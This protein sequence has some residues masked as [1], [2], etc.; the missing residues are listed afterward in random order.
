MSFRRKVITVNDKIA[1]PAM[2]VTRVV[3]VCYG[4]M[5]ATIVI[6]TGIGFWLSYAGLHSFAYRAGLRGPECWAWP[7][8]VDLFI[9]C[10]ELGIALSTLRDGKHDWRAWTYFAL[11]AVPSVTF[12]VMHVSVHSLAWA[13]YA[14]AATPPVTAALALAA[15][16]AQVIALPSVLQHL[17]LAEDTAVSDVAESAAAESP[18]S[19]PATQAPGPDSGPEDA[20]A[21]TT[22]QRPTKADP[23]PRKAVAR[24][25]GKRV[26]RTVAERAHAKYGEL[27]LSGA[28]VPSIRRIKSDLRLG[29]PKATEARVHLA[30]LSTSNG[31]AAEGD[32][33]D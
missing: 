30:T 14:V 26:S 8:S 10:G 4:I 29:T 25:T 19:I 20:P 22:A 23:R 15:V 18:A 21:T 16:M 33:H 28:P 32:Q 31:H 11:G 12:N 13:R 1:G 7:A 6:A 5:A 17:D 27:V 24:R 3:R 2:L 9:L